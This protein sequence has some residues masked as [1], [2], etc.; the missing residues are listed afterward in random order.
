M[1]W[2][3]TLLG[4]RMSPA[5]V[6]VAVNT[7]LAPATDPPIQAFSIEQRI[8]KRALDRRLAPLEIQENRGRIDKSR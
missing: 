1:D 6:G 2:R 4:Q 5:A 7:R 3:T 8:A